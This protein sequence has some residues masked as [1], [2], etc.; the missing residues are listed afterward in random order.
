MKTYS[1]PELR[2]L[3]AETDKKFEDASDEEVLNVFPDAL[4]EEIQEAYD[5]LSAI[6]HP[7]YYAADRYNDIKESLKRIVDRLH[8]AH[9]ELLERASVQQPL[10]EEDLHRPP[11]VTPEVPATAS[12]PAPEPPPQSQELSID[13]L[14]EALAWQPVNAKLMREL[15]LKLQR[16]GR[17]RDG[18]KHLQRA[19]EIEPHNIESHFALAQFYQLQ[20]LKFKAFK[21]LNI[22]LQLDPTNQKAM[23]LLGIKKRKGGL[24]EISN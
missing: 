18:E 10:L 9:H 15:G 4:S 24:Y 23:D 3:I 17:P 11:I 12:Q 20:G 22:I 13:A 19:L 2:K 14:Q 21:H 8:S 7:P 5:R 16:V 1:E 6:F